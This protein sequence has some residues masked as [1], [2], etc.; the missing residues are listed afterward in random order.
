MDLRNSL[1]FSLKISG[2]QAVS[3]RR[4]TLNNYSSAVETFEKFR[5]PDHELS[6]SQ[7]SI[8]FRIVDKFSSGLYAAYRRFAP[9]GWLNKY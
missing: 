6:K 5:Y 2:I 4:F 3:A 9:M 7:P 8:G 1:L